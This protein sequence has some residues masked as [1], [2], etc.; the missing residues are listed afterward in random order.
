MAEHNILGR[1]GEDE[2]CYYLLERDIHILER[3]WH[4]TDC[5]IDI[6]ADDYGEIIF[7]E[8]KTRTTTDYEM[9]EDAVDADRMY[10]MSRAAEEYLLRHDLTKNPY[11][12]DII[13]LNGTQP[14]FNIR[15]I[16]NAFYLKPKKRKR[17]PGIN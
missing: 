5:E 9:P 8:V 12:F 7:V 6:I 10:R 11:R 16:V 3:N 17:L 14:P 2:A 4:G 13:A 15:H 1:L